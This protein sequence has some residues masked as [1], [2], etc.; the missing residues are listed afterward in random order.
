MRVIEALDHVQEGMDL[1]GAVLFDIRDVGTLADV[2]ACL[3]D[4]TE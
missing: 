2:V 3:V 4:G 1:L